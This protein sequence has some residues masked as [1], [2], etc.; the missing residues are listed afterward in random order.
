MGESSHKAWHLEKKKRI[1][2]GAREQARRIEVDFAVG[3][4][5]IQRTAARRNVRRNHSAQAHHGKDSKIR[6]DFRN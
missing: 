3:S 2:L 1:R 5:M 6:P 4:K